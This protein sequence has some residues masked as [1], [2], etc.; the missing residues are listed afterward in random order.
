MAFPVT[1]NTVTIAASASLSGKT[2]VGHGQVVGFVLPSG[3]D[4]ADITL[5][6]SIDGETFYNL[7]DETGDTEVTVQA[8]ASRH[9][10][11][12]TPIRG[13]PW[14]KVRS[15]TAGAAVNQADAVDVIVVVSKDPMPSLRS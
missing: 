15:G 7:H 9:I 4:A 12:K 10:W 1:T 3:W 6:A 8:G 2:F 11:L 13:V 5:Q 14:I